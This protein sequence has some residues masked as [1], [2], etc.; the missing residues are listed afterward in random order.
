[1]VAIAMLRPKCLELAS[2]LSNNIISFIFLH[3]CL[4]SLMHIISDLLHSIIALLCMLYCIYPELVQRF[5]IVIVVVALFSLKNIVS[6][7]V[8]L[9]VAIKLFLVE[10]IDSNYLLST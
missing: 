10:Q 8:V 4:C 1:M 7:K 9:C 2:S 6:L 5:L 3:V